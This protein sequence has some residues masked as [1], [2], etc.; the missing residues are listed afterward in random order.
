MT[1]SERLRCLPPVPEGVSEVDPFANYGVQH[2]D[3][4]FLSLKCKPVIAGYS[5]SKWRQASIAFALQ[6]NPKCRIL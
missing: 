4:S 5:Y 6:V 2:A 1:A 3:E